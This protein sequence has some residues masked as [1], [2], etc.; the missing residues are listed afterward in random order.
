MKTKNLKF[1]QGDLINPEDF[2]ILYI[3]PNEYYKSNVDET[4]VA[5]KRRTGHLWICANRYDKRVH[6]SRTFY[7]KGHE[8]ITK[9]EY[10]NYWKPKLLLKAIKELE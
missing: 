7:F 6:K 10:D 1:G 9:E 4:H 8:C 2:V 5:F 3:S